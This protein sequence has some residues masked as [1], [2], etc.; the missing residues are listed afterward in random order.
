[1]GEVERGRRGLRKTG[2]LEGRD[3]GV[4]RGLEEMDERGKKR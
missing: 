1:M 3:N 2:R 4:E